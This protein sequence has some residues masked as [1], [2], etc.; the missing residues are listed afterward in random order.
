VRIELSTGYLPSLKLDRTG[1]IFYESQGTL[2]QKPTRGHRDKSKDG[3]NITLRL[4][5]LCGDSLTARSLSACL[6]GIT[7]YPAAARLAVFSG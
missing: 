3:R 5:S 4:C 7:I 2:P 6:G 1:P